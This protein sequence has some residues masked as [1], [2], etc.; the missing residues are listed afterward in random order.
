M[1]YR[2]LPQPSRES[3]M[4]P[5]QIASEHDLVMDANEV[6]GESG[7]NHRLRGETGSTYPQYQFVEHFVAPLMHPLARPSKKLKVRHADASTHHYDQSLQWSQSST[8]HQFSASSEIPAE[9]SYPPPGNIRSSPITMDPPVAQELIPSSALARNTASDSSVPLQ[10]PYSTSRGLRQFSMKVCE[11]VEEKGTTTYNEVADEVNIRC[12]CAIHAGLFWLSNLD[13]AIPHFTLLTDSLF[14]LKSKL[15]RELKQAEEVISAATIARGD[16]QGTNKINKSSKK[17]SKKSSSSSRTKQ[18]HDDKNIRRRVYDAL[19][20]L[21]AMD[22]ITK[23][24]KEITWRGLPGSAAVHQDHLGDGSG[25]RD[26]GEGRQLEG[27]GRRQRMQQLQAETSK[28]LD[29]IRTKRECLQEL[30]AQSVSFQNLLGRNYAKELEELRQLT[31]QIN[32]GKESVNL[33]V[34]EVKS[35]KIPLPFIIINTDSKAVVQC[36]ISS[37]RTNVSFDFSQPFEI[38]DDNE[39]LKRLGM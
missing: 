5:N 15:V 23:N 27:L 35:E 29:A 22:I 34:K 3:T 12:F 9:F 31:K 18:N 38:N 39:I 20:V 6:R 26:G 8:Q 19:N 36:E 4:V 33:K 14:R 32:S 21:M 24:K 2:Y 17:S 25:M 13:L 16:V 1:S 7:Q 11:K 28:R 30:I 10:N 37:E